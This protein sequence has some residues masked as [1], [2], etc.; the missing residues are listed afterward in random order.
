MGFHGKRSGAHFQSA[1][2]PGAAG[3][4]GGEPT[5]VAD[6]SYTEEPQRRPVVSKEW[7]PEDVFDVFGNELAREI[8]VLA[9]VEPMSAEELAERCER[10]QP[11]VYRRLNALE[12]YGLLSERQEVDPDG[13]HYKT[14]ETKLREVSFTIEDGGFTIDLDIRKDL[15]DKFSDFWTGMGGGDG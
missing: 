13:H 9:S 5:A 6:R 10:S 7:E 14:Y 3:R 15:V 2:L 1:K 8:L 11:T 12:S 4:T